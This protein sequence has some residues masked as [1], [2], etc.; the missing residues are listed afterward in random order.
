MNFAESQKMIVP[1]TQH[2]FESIARDA[3]EWSRVLPVGVKFGINIALY[4]LHSESFKADI[5]YLSTSLPTPFPIL[6]GIYA[7]RDAKE[8]EATQL[9]ALLHSVGVEIAIDDFGTGHSALNPPSVLRSI[10]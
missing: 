9:F 8:Q 6:R 3:A 4:Y 1:L 5:Q 10:I 2:L 7:A